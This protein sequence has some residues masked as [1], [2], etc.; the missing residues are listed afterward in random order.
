MTVAAAVGLAL[1]LRRAGN[2]ATVV[3]I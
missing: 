1:R 3:V 2:R